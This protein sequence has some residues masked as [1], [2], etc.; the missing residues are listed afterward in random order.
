M[1]RSTGLTGVGLV[2]MLVALTGFLNLFIGSASA[3]WALIGPVLVP[4]FMLVGIAPEATQAAYRIGDSVT[5]IITPLMPYFPM[6]IVFARRY[7]KDFGVGSLIAVMLPYSISF[8]LGGILFLV[9]WMLLGIPL[10]PG[11]G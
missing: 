5:N 2:V 3:K 6:V 4:M 1:I 9:A 8:G 11:L 7:E 10:G